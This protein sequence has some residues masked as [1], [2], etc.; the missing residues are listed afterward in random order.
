ML[1]WGITDLLGSRAGEDVRGRVSPR[2]AY[3]RPYPGDL[4]RAA[5]SAGETGRD[6][7]L[8]RAG[9]QDPPPSAIGDD[10]VTTSRSTPSTAS[11]A[12]RGRARPALVPAG[13]ATGRARR[14]RAAEHRPWRPKSPACCRSGA[15]PAGATPSPTCSARGCSRSAPTRRVSLDPGGRDRLGRHPDRRATSSFHAP[16]RPSRWRSTRALAAAPARSRA[17]LKSRREGGK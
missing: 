17:G 4:P 16:S 10:A 5:D 14:G 3:R 1:D 2:T 12:G 15:G 9:E 13:L 6:D 7:G 8:Q 11:A